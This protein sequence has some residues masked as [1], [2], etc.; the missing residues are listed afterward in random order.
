MLP[1][2]MLVADRWK[3]YSVIDTSGGEKLEDFGGYLLIRPDPQVIWD[4]ERRHRG[5]K[6]PNAHYHRSKNGGGS[7]EFFDLLL[8]KASVVVTP[9]SGF[10]PAGEGYVRVSAYGHREDV[11]KAVKSIEEN[12]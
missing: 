2:F 9:G 8:D 4:T 5:W 6:K 10:G 12:L 3:E 7:W 11:E 1:F